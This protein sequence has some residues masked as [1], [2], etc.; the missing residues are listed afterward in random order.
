MVVGKGRLFTDGLNRA[1]SKKHVLFWQK[2][3]WAACCLEGAPAH[4]PKHF[5]RVA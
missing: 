4:R 1:A 3:D 2:M 5:N